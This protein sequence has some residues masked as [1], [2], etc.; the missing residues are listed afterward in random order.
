MVARDVLECVDCGGVYEFSF[1]PYPQLFMPSGDYI[2]CNMVKAL[3]TRT[4][5]AAKAHS[6]A[7]NE[8]RYSG[9]HPQARAFA[10]AH[11]D[12]LRW[13][14]ARKLQGFRGGWRKGRNAMDQIRR[15]Q[16][17]LGRELR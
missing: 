9:T 13:Y 6:R 17:K 1:V 8:A 10:E 4:L 14:A 5:A 7:L 11:G 16:D 12:E 3:A 15:T 2:D